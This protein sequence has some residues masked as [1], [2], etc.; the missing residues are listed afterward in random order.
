MTQQKTKAEEKK[1]NNKARIV[2]GEPTYTLDDVLAQAQAI[3]EK[4]EVLAGALLPLGK[5]EFTRTEIKKAIK[6]FKNKEVI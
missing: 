1:T 2:R 5:E 3:G 4:E 6:D